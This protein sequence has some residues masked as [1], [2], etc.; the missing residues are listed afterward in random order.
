[1]SDAERATLSQAIRSV[2]VRQGSYVSVVQGARV[3]QPVVSLALHGRLVA[4]TP[5]VERLFEYLGIAPGGSGA[6]S[7]LGDASPNDDARI[8]RLVGMLRGLSDG[9]KEADDRL[10]AVLAA[11]Q[12]FRPLDV[13]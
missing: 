12:G 4:R 9:S 13:R 3:P 5:S 11:L 10:A 2:M 6:S 7:T 1:M 8:R